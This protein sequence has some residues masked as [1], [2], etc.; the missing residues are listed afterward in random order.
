MTITT[1]IVGADPDLDFTQYHD[2][3]R[4]YIFNTY[5][6]LTANN[7]SQNGENNSIIQNSQCNGKG[8]VEVFS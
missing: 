2:D 1:D 5:Y 7:K 6:L 4:V 3:D 8:R